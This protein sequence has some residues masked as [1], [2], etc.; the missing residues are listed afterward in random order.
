VLR[1]LHRHS[2][3]HRRSNGLR[4][5][6]R[7]V[8]LCGDELGAGIP[9]QTETTTPRISKT[10]PNTP[11]TSRASPGPWESAPMADTVSPRTMN[12]HIESSSIPV[13]TIPPRSSIDIRSFDG[14]ERA[15]LVSMNHR[16]A[17]VV[18]WPS[19]SSLVQS[20][21]PRSQTGAAFFGG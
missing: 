6:L 21:A 12:A 10:H 2:R 1:D 4:V 16:P 20:W 13:Y 11:R 14:I 9:L 19:R 17:D 18:S 7:K 15:K 3:G 5:G 8:L